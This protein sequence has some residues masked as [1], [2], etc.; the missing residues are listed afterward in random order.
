MCP[1][2]CRSQLEKEREGIKE[3]VDEGRETREEKGDGGKQ[4]RGREERLRKGGS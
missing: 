4:L 3:E 2:V 1:L